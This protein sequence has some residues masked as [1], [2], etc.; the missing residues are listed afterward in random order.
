LTRHGPVITDAYRAAADAMPSG[1]V[2]SLAWVGLRPDDLTLEFSVKAARAKSA[3]ALRD[4]ARSFHSPQENI[5]FADVDGEVGFVAAGRVPI[6]TDSSLRGRAPAPGWDARFDWSGFIP[7]DELPQGLGRDLAPVVSANQKLTPEGYPYWMS[8]AW[9]PPKRA[10]RIAALLAATPRHDLASFSAIQLDQR[11]TSAAELGRRLAVIEGASPEEKQLVRALRSWDGQMSADR[12]E[13]LIF[14]EWLRQLTTSLYAKGAASVSGLLDDYNP[15]FVE[16]VLSDEAA[17]SFWCRPATGRAPCEAEV[18][19]ALTLTAKRLTAAYGANPA[20]WAWG[21]ANSARFT[22]RSL[23]SVPLLSRWLEVRLPRGGGPES[24]NVSSYAFDDASGEYAT[25]SGPGFRAVYDL[26]NLEN[27][28]FIVTP[29]QSGHPLSRHYRDL[30]ESWE[31]G[32]Y[33]SIRT[34]PSSAEAA[35]WQRLLLTPR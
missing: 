17:A 26:S 21:N 11:D 5:V 14:A 20:D 13:P 27:S 35:A 6:R 34:R 33:L 2:L 23:G 1:M 25:E 8:A 22:H 29:G 19:S 24:V 28:R 16:K 9:A 30:A 31:Q 18:A 12:A 3:L 7:F 4:A 32:R 15:A 10:R